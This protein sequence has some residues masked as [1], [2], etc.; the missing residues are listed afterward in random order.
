MVSAGF[1]HLFYTRNRNFGKKGE[2]AK[3]LY[4]SSRMLCLWSAL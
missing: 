4:Y 1:S 3:D 2:H